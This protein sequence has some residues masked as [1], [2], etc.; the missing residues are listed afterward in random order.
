MITASPYVREEER[1]EELASYN[2][3]DSLEE[4]DYDNLTALASHICGTSIS[5]ISLLDDKRQWFKSHHGLG[6]TETN[7]DFAF[8]AH[9]INQSETIFEIPDARIDERFAN[10]PLVTSDPNIVFYAG[11]PLIGDNNLPLGTL[12]VIDPKPQVLTEIQKKSL[13]S[14]GQQVMNLIKLRKRNLQLSETISALEETNHNLDRFAMIAAHDL[15]SP[16]NNI[17]AL[18]DLFKMQY[19]SSLDSEGKNLLEMI[20]SSSA[21]LKRLID[22]LL[23]YSKS[24]LLVKEQKTSVDLKCLINEIISLLDGASSVSVQ[25]TTDLKKVNVNRTVLYHVL[26]NLLSNAI[27]YNRNPK[28]Q[29]VVKASESDKHYHFSVKDNGPGVPSD[30]H[31]KMFELFSI[32]ESSDTSGMTGTGVGLAMVKKLIET[33]QGQ[34]EVDSTIGVGSTF[35][36]TLLK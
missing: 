13:K 3:L 26:L 33:S 34:I 1:L 31:A 22:G 4:E 14:L 23:T 21:K 30:S 10:N 8:C 11:V 36:F 2:I 35:S 6:A 27:K 20:G 17:L 16:L 32:L 15:K 12:C 5:L 18:T 24:D 19:N 7:K 28:P 25:I 9:A 29:I